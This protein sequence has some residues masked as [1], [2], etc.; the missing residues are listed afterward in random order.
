MRPITKQLYTF[1]SACGGNW[2]NTIYVY[3]PA[4]FG[5]GLLMAFDRDARPVLMPLEQLRGISGEDIDPSE[6]RSRL[7]R[8]AFEDIFAQFLLWQRTSTETDPLTMG[9]SAP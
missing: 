5:D 1:L 9:D 7:D 2:R 3:D 4:R 8:A 6:C